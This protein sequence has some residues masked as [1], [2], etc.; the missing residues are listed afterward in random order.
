AGPFS[1]DELSTY[2]LRKSL[3]TSCFATASLDHPSTSTPFPL[4]RRQACN[5]NGKRIAGHSPLKGM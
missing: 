1:F 3:L 5:P 4:K 2:L